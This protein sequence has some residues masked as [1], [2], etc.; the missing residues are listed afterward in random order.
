M[1]EIARYGDYSNASILYF[2]FL[3]FF[4]FLT[5]KSVSLF[6]DAQAI[7]F[8]ALPA[9]YTYIAC[10]ATIIAI[11]LLLYTGYQSGFPLLDGVDRFIFKRD[12][13]SYAFNFI[14]GNRFVIAMMLGIV[15]CASS[16]RT[17]GILICLIFLSFVGTMFLFG[18]KFFSV[19]N[20]AAYFLMPYLLSSNSKKF[21]S[22]RL[23]AAVTFVLAICFAVTLYI[24]T[25][26]GQQDLSVGW[27]RVGERLA[28]QGQLW[29]AAISAPEAATYSGQQ[30][31]LLFENFLSLDADGRAFKE[32]I[33]IYY[34]MQTY[35]PGSTLDG[36]AQSLG[37]V[38][39]TMGTEAYLMLV[40]GVPVLLIVMGGFAAVYGIALSYLA[41]CIRRVDMIGCILVMKYLSYCSD[42]LNQVTLWNPFGYKGLS[43]LLLIFLYESTKKHSK[44]LHVYYR[45]FARIG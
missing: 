18:E 21:L 27:E 42:A 7:K 30:S 13:A 9:R 39:Y 24:Y 12:S 17:T 26:Y 28:G 37:L 6:G 16:N 29:Y 5:Q 23:L 38:T 8:R 33:G 20:S 14:I 22:P 45:P 19:I 44:R 40:F 10:S 36:L 31:S 3:I 25:D 1:K 34:L 32:G 15:L 2:L 41:K 43:V 35:A 11:S 4:V